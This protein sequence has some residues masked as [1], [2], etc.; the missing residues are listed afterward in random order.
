MTDR[1]LVLVIGA[2]TPIDRL[3]SVLAGVGAVNLGPATVRAT[4]GRD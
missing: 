4:L 3:G 1:T 2:R